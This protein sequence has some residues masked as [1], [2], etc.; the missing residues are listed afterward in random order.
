MNFM[1]KLPALESMP[2]IPPPAG[3]TAPAA[4]TLLQVAPAPAVG[5]AA[6]SVA[7]LVFAPA[8]LQT[9]N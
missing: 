6:D 5:F 9:R 8:V 4:V 3:M 7:D 1:I 2:P